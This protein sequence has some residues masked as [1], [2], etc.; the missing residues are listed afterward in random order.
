VPKPRRGPGWIWAGRIAAAM[1]LTGLVIY[2]ARAGLD[3]ADKL[4]S[5]ISVVVALGAL[6][7][8]YLLPV[9]SR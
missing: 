2:L 1:I 8:P 4:G 5:S 7:A 6:L 3:T 9:R